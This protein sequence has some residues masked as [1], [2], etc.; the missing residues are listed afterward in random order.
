MKDLNN[1]A[2]EIIAKIDY[3]T[4]AS[5]TP[6]GMPWNT[7]VYSAFDKDYNFYWGTH[8]DSQKAN[9]IR[10]NENVFLVIYDSTVPPGTGEGVFIQAKAQQLSDPDEIQHAYETLRD[11]RPTPFWK[12]EAFSEEGP[13]RLFKAVPQK[14]WMNDD[15][16][17]NGHYID[18]R[19]EIEL[20]KL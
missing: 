13:V 5:V 6:E 20:W 1:R 18:I 2:K 9:N 16:E 11:R 19:T 10:N 17:K 14:A 8:I 7:P 3:I 12:P 15:G 4:I